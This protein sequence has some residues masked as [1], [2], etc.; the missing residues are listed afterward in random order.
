MRHFIFEKNMP[1]LA[2]ITNHWPN[3]KHLLK[4]FILSNQKKPNFYKLCISCLNE[5]NVYKIGNFKEVIKILSKKSS[6]NFTFNSYHDQHHFKSVIIIS[7]LL[8]KLSNFKAKEDIIWLILIA[9]THD[10]FHQ[11]RRII[12]TSY[13]QEEKSFKELYFVAF[14]KLLNH[15]KFKRFEKIFR[16]TYFPIKPEKV[17][18]ELEKIILDADILASLMF[19]MNTGIKLAERLKHEI[20][21]E[22]RSDVLFV[23]FVKFLSTKDLYLKTSKNSC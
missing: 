14:K 3:T 16:S 10:L 18:D 11:G 21:F 12:K 9:L 17:D 4:K 8:A 22:G 15:K 19:G 5:L 6:M 1:S 23:G 7:C 2:Y 13:Y 20:R